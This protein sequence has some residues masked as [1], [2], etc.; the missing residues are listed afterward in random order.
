MQRRILVA[1]DDVELR[2]TVA[3]Y[4]RG[5]GFEVDE[6][7]NGASALS[8]ARAAPPDVLLLDLNMPEVDGPA[9]LEDWKSSADLKDVPVV[10][11]SA[12][13]DLA[14]VAQQYGV[15]ASLAKPFDMDVLR[16]VIDQL[17]VHPEPPP[18]A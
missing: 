18:E 4:L 9:V 13:P 16:A 5:E 11:V 15:R 12:G 7:D 6:A 8:V 1:E 2:S 10:L 14:D 3:E 17:V